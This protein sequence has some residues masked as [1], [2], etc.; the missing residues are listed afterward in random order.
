[1]RICVLLLTYA[2]CFLGPQLISIISFAG[3]FFSAP[4]GFLIPIIAYNKH[5]KSK[6]KLLPAKKIFNLLIFFV[7]GVMSLISVFQSAISLFK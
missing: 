7:G 5:F 3:S 6:N 4:L 1:M 2:I